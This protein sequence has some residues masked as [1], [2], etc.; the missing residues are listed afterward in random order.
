MNIEVMVDE[1]R[2]YDS[3]EVYV[4]CDS[5][6]SNDLIQFC[7]DIDSRLDQRTKRVTQDINQMHRIHHHV[8]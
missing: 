2:V 5:L 8:L 6:A 4:P 7:G 1:S 3:V